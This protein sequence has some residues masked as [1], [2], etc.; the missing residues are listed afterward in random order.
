MPYHRSHTG[1]IV[2]GI[3]AAI[4]VVGLVALVVERVGHRS[5]DDHGFTAK[6]PGQSPSPKPRKVRIK[7]PRQAQ[8]SSSASPASAAAADAPTWMLGIPEAGKLHV[9]VESVPGAPHQ[10]V[11]SVVSSSG[12]PIA[13]KYAFRTGDHYTSGRTAVRGSSWRQSATVRGNEP[14]AGVVAQV[15]PTGSVT[16]TVTLDGRVVDT[17]T[18]SGSWAVVYCGA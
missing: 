4:L 14:L 16:C 9:D 18:R 13:L 10:A 8:A 12:S 15:G 3:L 7:H 1:R 2:A 5:A 17:K 6:D 11:I